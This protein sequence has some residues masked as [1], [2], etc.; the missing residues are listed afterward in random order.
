MQLSL[1]IRSKLFL[2]TLLILLVSYLT[3]FVTTFQSVE[4]Y[5]EKDMAKDMAAHL[6]FT[7]NQYFYRAD[8]IK[9]SLMQPILAP[10]VQQHLQRRDAAWFRDAISRWHKVLPFVDTLSVMDADKTVVAR[11]GSG[12]SGDRFGLAPLVDRAFRD[13]RVAISTELVPFSYLCREGQPGF[14]PPLPED[15]EAMLVMVVLPVFAPDGTLLGAVAAG[16]MIN[17]DPA[18]SVQLKEI[19]GKDTEVNITQRGVRVAGSS[20]VE[21]FLNLEPQILERLEKGLSYR[22]ETV[23]GDKSFE[24]VFEPITNSRG[25]FVG[26]L[27]VAISKESLRTVRRDHLKNIFLSALIGI[28]LS[29]GVAFA[30]AG[31]LTGPLRKLASSARMIEAGDLNQRVMVRERDEVG[32]LAGSFNRMASALAE[33]NA[34]ITKK[35]QDLQELNELLEKKVSD[36]TG[37][38]SMGLG[39]LE[40]VLT[41]M[42]EGVVVTDKDNRVILFNT[43]AQK[44]FDLVPFR[45]VGQPLEQV[46]SMGEFNL[47]LDSI[48]E[49][50]AAGG[51]VTGRQEDME[52]R[53]KKLKINLSL[54]VDEGG[55]FSGVVISIRDVTAEEEVDRMKTEFIA[56]VSHE[57]KTPLTSMKGS[58]QLILN[59]GKWLTDTER[60]LLSVCLRNTQ[61]LIRLISEILDISKIESGGMIFNLKPL[62]MGEL[63]VYAAEEIKS[64]AQSRSISIVN[65]V[66][67]HLPLVYGDHDRLIQVLTNLLSNAVKFSPEGKVVMV[68]AE[69]DGNYLKISVADRGMVIPWGDRDKLFKKFQRLQSSDQQS[70]GG[71]GLGLVI[72]KEIVE[73]HHGRIYYDASSESGNVFT[74]TVPIFEESHGKG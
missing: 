64:L 70:Q 13:K 18:L 48:R 8:Q 26:S 65:S 45:V 22:G 19:F 14:C 1:G 71:T 68:M 60:Q 23:F 16:D 46:C 57:L 5:I 47:L 32:E 54:M 49:L 41:C 53:G 11:L 9:Y 27:S 42:A 44:I 6:K 31:K 33:R 51:A 21:S 4:N 69:R 39:R 7:W 30:T 72:C 61:R 74:F 43:A 56:T 17:N 25:D 20:A 38:L 67:S 50:R 3:L 36:R 24:T 34:V 29:F 63:V 55:A 52:V 40:A 73:K 37:E 28:L 58:L 35:N 2:S 66:G 10:P 59:R 12:E 15:G 62:S